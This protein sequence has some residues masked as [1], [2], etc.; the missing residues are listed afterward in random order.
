MFCKYCGKGVDPNTMRCRGCGRPVGPLAGGT[1]FW[2]LSEGTAIQQAEAPAAAELAELREKIEALQE[3]SK[4]EN[5]GG[6]KKGSAFLPV[7]AALLA[8][9]GLGLGIF[10][11]LTSSRAQQETAALLTAQSEQ[12]AALEER[13]GALDQEQK[14]PRFSDASVVIT[15]PQSDKAYVGKAS[16]D[17][18]VADGLWIFAA[19]FQGSYGPYECYWV[20]L[21]GDEADPDYVRVSDI[22]G[23]EEVTISPTSSRLYILGPVQE[24]HFGSYAFMVKDG[25]GLLHMSKIAQLEEEP[26]PGAPVQGEGQQEGAQEGAEGNDG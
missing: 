3:R 17:G 20:K 7:T 15:G 23:F 5:T 2:D 9:V 13:I 6:S 10:S 21:E 14:S 11:F 22:G 16:S 24:S 4:G 12:I 18:Y 19:S 25:S 1:G 8:A 26:V